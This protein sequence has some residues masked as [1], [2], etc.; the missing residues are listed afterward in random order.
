MKLSD[1]NKVYDLRDERDNLLEILSDIERG[2]NLQISS[3]SS[4]SYV[5]I[6]ATEPLYSALAQTA[7]DK[8]TAVE[9]GLKALG[10]QIDT[11]STDD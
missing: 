1:F 8:L 9:S 3:D 10:I 5:E 4:V 7:R 11:N 6:A 2:A